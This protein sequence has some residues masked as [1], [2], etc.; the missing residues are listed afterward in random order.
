MRVTVGNRIEDLRKVLM[1]S[2][3]YSL[4]KLRE[5]AE[6]IEAW[7]KKVWLLSLFLSPNHTHPI[8]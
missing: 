7:L 4:Q 3:E 1:A 8:S 6:E 5:L 2:S